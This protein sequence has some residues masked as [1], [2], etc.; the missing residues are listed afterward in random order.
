MPD[1]FFGELLTPWTYNIGGPRLTVET[2]SE[3]E[4]R[5]LRAGANTTGTVSNC[6]FRPINTVATSSG[7]RWEA[8]FWPS[9]ASTNTLT[10]IY[11]RFP[12]KLSS[13]TDR[14]VAGYQHDDAV[15]QAIIAEA[16]RQKGDV[17]GPRNQ[18]YQVALKRSLATDA[19]AAISKLP[20][21]GDRSEDRHGGGRPLSYY[22][23]STYNG[24]RIP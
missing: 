8:L 18:E 16:E 19:R 23:V 1:D 3:Y 4:I 15:M 13:G 6:A 14:S 11:K 10:A 22:G 7:S 9:P 20:G 2:V 21:Y 24:A 17:S 5:E 12:Q